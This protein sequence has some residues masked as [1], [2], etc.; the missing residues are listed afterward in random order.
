MCTVHP[1]N[2]ERHQLVLES[3]SHSVVTTT[4]SCVSSPCTWLVHCLNQSL[5][6]LRNALQNR[7]KDVRT[8]TDTSVNQ[9][10]DEDWSEKDWVVV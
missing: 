5:V 9:T 3:G 10:V 8:S 4:E 7:K 6:A 2:N 1:G